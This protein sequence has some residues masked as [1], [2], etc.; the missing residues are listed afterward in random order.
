[1]GTMLSGAAPGSRE[2][3]GQDAAAA[4][5][6]APQ[7]PWSSGY[8]QRYPVLRQELPMPPHLVIRAGREQAFGQ[9]APS[10]KGSEHLALGEVGDSVASLHVGTLRALQELKKQARSVPRGQTS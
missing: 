4:E 8:V 1:M 9:A 7:G 3:L 2:Q 10:S 6:S 5:A